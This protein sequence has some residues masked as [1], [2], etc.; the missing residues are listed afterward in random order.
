MRY[1]QEYRHKFTNAPGMVIDAGK[2]LLGYIANQKRLSGVDSLIQRIAVNDESGAVW[3]VEARFDKDI[4]SVR[5]FPPNSDSA[6]CEL[7]VESGLLDLGPNI[8]ADAGERF[9]RGLPQFSEDPATLYFGTGV[10][11]VEGQPGLNGAVRLQ[12]QNVASDCLPNI[13]NGIASRLTNPV[14][15][16]AQALQPAS[17]WSGLMQRYVQAVYGGDT[18]DYSATAA[19]L[20]IGGVTIPVA[21][22]VGLLNIGGALRFLVIDGGTL[23]MYQVRPSSACVL[24]VLQ[25]WASMPDDDEALRDRK[26]KVLT[27]ALSGC[28]IGPAVG[29]GTISASGNHHFT[30]RAAWV[31]AHDAPTAVAVFENDGVATAYEATFT[32]DGDVVSAALTTLD[33]GDVLNAGEWPLFV[34]DQ[35]PYG[36]AVAHASG[37][38]T[39]PDALEA[40]QTFDFPV[41]ATYEAGEPLVVS[42]SLVSSSA[43]ITDASLCFDRENPYGPVIIGSD[44]SRQCRSNLVDTAT[45]A[46]GFYATGWSTVELND[47][48]LDDDDNV[49]RSLGAGYQGVAI[50]GTPGQDSYSS[51]GDTRNRVPAGAL[52]GPYTVGCQVY[53]ET[54]GTSPVVVSNVE[55]GEPCV[56]LYQYESTD[57]P[58]A[59]DM[60]RPYYPAAGV[61]FDG[62]AKGS[63]L[64]VLSLAW[65]AT[66]CLVADQ[67]TFNGGRGGYL[68]FTGAAYMI[69]NATAR[70]HD[71]A[72]LSET[73]TR[74]TFTY[75]TPGDCDSGTTLTDTSPFGAIETTTL[76]TAEGDLVLGMFGF[77]S[78]YVDADVLVVNVNQPSDTPEGDALIVYPD[79]RMRGV[80]MMTS[81]VFM[82]GASNE[83]TESNSVSVY[84]PD[85]GYEHP[86]GPGDFVANDDTEGDCEA[87]RYL[88]LQELTDAHLVGDLAEDEDMD[89]V[90]QDLGTPSWLVE[91][92]AY[93]SAKS[94]LGACVVPTAMYQ[95]GAS[96]NMDRQTI[97]GG[98]SPVSTPSFV[99]W[100]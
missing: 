14:K 89:F 17:N 61:V 9:N 5:I 55:Y 79:P 65:G 82:P 32:L 19:A 24:A 49:V 13:G 16:Q 3:L 86:D 38:A 2:K 53:N 7:Y 71:Y 62:S 12:G 88:G 45:V 35:N 40:G 29:S 27:I 41:Y 73:K 75:N 60:T 15:K 96:L 99:G 80:E 50:G 56:T 39:T 26:N 18:L 34:A 100:A 90:L 92:F 21:D 22:S 84:V 42:C 83:A 51:D 37:F 98:Y 64:Q 94:L 81:S 70:V 76:P 69:F 47:C 66:T 43:P 28:V 6:V 78:P 87:Y 68:S 33:S 48:F 97:T 1:F 85:S 52:S 11:C 74:L 31:F 46:Y 72:S 54:A 20:T 59:C 30:N 36:E 93:Q 77:A 25:A 44:T 63:G 10:E 58:I 91:G 8:A 67:Y 4:P 23:T 57:D 95:R